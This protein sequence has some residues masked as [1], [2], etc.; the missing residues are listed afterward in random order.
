[1]KM[2]GKKVTDVI[3]KLHLAMPSKRDAKVL[4]YT[5]HRVQCS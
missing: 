1:M 5:S 2:K 4:L 3:N